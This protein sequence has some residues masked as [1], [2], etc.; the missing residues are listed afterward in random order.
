MVCRRL[1]KVILA[2]EI[3]AIDSQNRKKIIKQLNIGMHAGLPFGRLDGSYP[4]RCH[5][6]LSCGRF[7]LFQEEEEQEEE[8]HKCFPLIK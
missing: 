2:L 4:A 8:N 7:G 3:P 1:T 5:P 6:T